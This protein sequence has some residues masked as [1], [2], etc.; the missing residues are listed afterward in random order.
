MKRNPVEGILG[1][2]VLVFAGAFLFLASAHV[3]VKTVKGYTLSAAFSKIG[4]L[5]MGADVRIN[6]IKVG[7]VTQIRLDEENYQALVEMTIKENIRLPVDT[8]ALIADA[9]IMGD[10]YIR[11]EPG[12]SEQKLSPGKR[13]TKTKDYKS[14]EDS[15]SEFIYL[16]TKDD[17]KK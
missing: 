17:V 4:G 12:Y 7:S 13:I 11:L 8:T 9:G 3:D 5:E 15:V 14:L 1:L 10:K 16:S 2:L 6:G